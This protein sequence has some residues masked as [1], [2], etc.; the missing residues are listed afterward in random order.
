ML[1]SRVSVKLRLMADLLHKS[2]TQPPITHILEF[3]PE[4]RLLFYQQLFHNFCLQL[5][6]D[7]Q[8][9]P[10]ECQP[11]TAVNQ[12]CKVNKQIRGEALPVLAASL[13]ILC[14]PELLPQ[15]DADAEPAGTGIIVVPTGIIVVPKLKPAFMQSIKCLSISVQGAYIPPHSLFTGLRKVAIDAW[16][17]QNRLKRKKDADLVKAVED[18]M[19]NPMIRQFCFPPWLTDLQQNLGEDVSLA[20]QMVWH[21]SYEAEEKSNLVSCVRIW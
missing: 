2:P 20:I 14:A 8:C 9:V 16:L 17:V 5:E 10:Y 19:K 12:I 11:E 7:G 1:L 6:A 18:D 4:I 21:F 3:P 13:K 15:K